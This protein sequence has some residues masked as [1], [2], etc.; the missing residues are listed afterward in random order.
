MIGI[1]LY[2]DK[3]NFSNHG[4]FINAKHEHLLVGPINVSDILVNLS[5][6]LG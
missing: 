4:N 2:H 1:L 6:R 3:V 5:C